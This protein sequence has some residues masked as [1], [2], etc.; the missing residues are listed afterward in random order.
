MIDAMLVGTVQNIVS[1]KLDRI[2]P[3]LEC[4]VGVVMVQ[5]LQSA[6]M[7]IAGETGTVEIDTAEARLLLTGVEV[8]EM[9]TIGSTPVTENDV[10]MTTTTTEVDR[11]VVAEAEIGV[12]MVDAIE[13]RGLV[14]ISPEI[15]TKRLE[16]DL[17]ID[18]EIDLDRE[19]GLMKDRGTGLET[20]TGTVVDLAI[21][22]VI[23]KD[24]RTEEKGTVKTIDLVDDVARV[25]IMWIVR[26]YLKGGNQTVASA[27][28]LPKTMDLMNEPMSQGD[29]GAVVEVENEVEKVGEG[30]VVHEAEVDLQAKEVF[31]IS[32]LVLFF[33]YHMFSN[34]QVNNLF[35]LTTK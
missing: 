27:P 3:I 32:N 12:E 31:R 1:V 19:K 33:L 23:E 6:I 30:N 2:F 16:I 18:T 7:T 17:E 9:T 15:D 11:E 4:Q 29:V 35:W 28:K 26:A 24:R 25:L 20:G 14:E 13:R 5:I 8:K 10:I 22:L 34:E 21:D